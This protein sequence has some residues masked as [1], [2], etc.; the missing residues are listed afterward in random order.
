V[1]GPGLDMADDFGVPALLRSK[2]RDA[3]SFCWRSGAT[4]Q[5][6]TVRGFTDGDIHAG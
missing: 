6:V 1:G 2:V 4:F 5:T 3:A